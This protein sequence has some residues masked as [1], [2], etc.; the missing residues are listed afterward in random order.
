MP[1]PPSY[2]CGRITDEDDIPKIIQMENVDFFAQN[3]AVA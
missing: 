3:Y 1:T 2:F